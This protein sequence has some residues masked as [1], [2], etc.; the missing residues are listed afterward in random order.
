MIENLTQ[1]DINQAFQ[2]LSEEDKVVINRISNNLITKIKAFGRPKDYNG[3]S[4][5]FTRDNALEL[6]AKTGIWMVENA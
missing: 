1:E 6:L 3:N 2:K 5:P 4:Y